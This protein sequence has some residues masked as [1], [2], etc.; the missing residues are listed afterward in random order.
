MYLSGEG[1]R[2]QEFLTSGIFGLQE[3][4]DFKKK[5]TSRILALQEF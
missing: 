5:G 2:L 3:F 1:E 4:L